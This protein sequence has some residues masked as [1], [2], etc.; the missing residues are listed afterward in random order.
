MSAF[1]IRP[2]KPAAAYP[3]SVNEHEGLLETE[4]Q[5]R[6]DNYELFKAYPQGTIVLTLPNRGPQGQAN[7]GIFSDEHK[8]LSFDTG[9]GL[10]VLSANMPLEVVTLEAKMKQ[11]QFHPVIAT[12]DFTHKEIQLMVDGG[13]LQKRRSKRR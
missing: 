9:K 10:V 4:A 2:I 8:K 11:Q 5:K 12:W 3:D 6:Q 13:P 1:L 7:V